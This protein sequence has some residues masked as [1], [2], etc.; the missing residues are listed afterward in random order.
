MEKN[1]FM[2]KRIIFLI[3]GILFLFGGFS[4]SQKQADNSIS[5]VIILHTN[6]MHAKID[7]MGKLAYLADSLRK[8]F[9]IVFLV[10]AGDNFTGNPVVDMVA[11]IGYP[12]IDLMNLC[13]FNFS[14][15]GN[16][17]FD[18]G[19]K[20]LKNRMEQASF[21]FICCNIDVSGTKMTQPKPFV[22]LK[23]ENDIEIPFLGI[24]QLGANGLPDSHPSRFT[25]L[26]FTDGIATAK[27]YIWL[28]EKYGILIGLTHLGV[29]ND[30]ELALTMPQFDLLIGGHSHT[31][32]DS[33]MTVNGVMI[34]QAASGLKYVGKTTLMLENNHVTDRRDEIICLDS[35]SR[36]NAKVQTLID[37]YNNNQE[38]LRIVGVAEVP[39]IGFDE[40]G[41]FI[42]DALRNQLKVDFAFMNRRGIR[43][44]ALQEGNISLKD[45]YQLDPFQNDVITLKMS[46]NE[47]ISLICNA[48]NLKNMIDLAV[49]GMSYT[50]ITD[51]S[52]H[53]KS[54]EMKDN[55]G[56]AI[57][58]FHD[59]TV[60]INSYI[61][62]AYRFDHH[63]Q[64]SSTGLTSEEILVNYLQYIKKINYT[65]VKRTFLKPAQKDEMH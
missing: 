47:I 42:S 56:A 55:A 45:I 60:A 59:Y 2:N 33:L 58:P 64:G 27:D 35:I 63:D 21:P 15:L 46:G 39:I 29:E 22:I 44:N 1:H 31:L 11:D 48:Y 34:V 62:S 53:C 16:H 4:Y 20:F 3:T 54:V 12:M 7:N 65:D 40:L 36:V 26:K 25:G 32:I 61:A 28:K 37:Y 19:Q 23:A 18:M 24:L 52:G 38:I 6:D 13:G 51:S 17:E 14:A 8:I 50:V 57:D 10:S 41:S 9:P 43:I 49:S 5:E 30:K